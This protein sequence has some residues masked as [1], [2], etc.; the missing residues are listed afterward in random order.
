MTRSPVLL[1]AL[2]RALALAVPVVLTAHPALAI[3]L[4]PITVQVCSVVEALT[5]PL[6]KGAALLAIAACAIMMFYGRLQVPL[7]VT[8][9]IACAILFGAETIVTG[10]A[11]GGAC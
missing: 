10:I 8:M 1:R 3:D 7:L 6:G 11:G 5:G 2:L 9:L 4:S